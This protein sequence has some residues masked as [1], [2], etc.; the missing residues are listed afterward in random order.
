M[1]SAQPASHGW[2]YFENVK[3]KQ[4]SISA[5][6]EHR[7]LDTRLSPDIIGVQSLSGFNLIIKI[8]LLG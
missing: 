3:H 1:D 8:E 6:Q 5:K 2:L 7:I 4:T